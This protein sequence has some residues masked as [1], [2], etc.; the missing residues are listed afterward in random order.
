MCSTAVVYKLNCKT[1]ASTWCRDNLNEILMLGNKLY[2][3]ISNLARNLLSEI[4]S[5]LSINDNCSGDLHMSDIRDCFLPLQNVLNMLIKDNNAFL[6][7]IESN[8]VA[9]IFDNKGHYRIFDSH[10]QDMYG[11]LT[12]N[13]KAIMLELN[14]IEKIVQYLQNFYSEK[15]V[16]SFE[17]LGIKVSNLSDS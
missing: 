8:T 17:L 9:I 4:P 7:T 6:L 3:H 5:A 13:G 11:D 12:V 14:S 1:N 16:F 10:S 2:S 15:S